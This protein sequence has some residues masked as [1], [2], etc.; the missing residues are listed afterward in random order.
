MVPMPML[1]AVR[2]RPGPSFRNLSSIAAAGLALAACA[3]SSAGPEVV[4]GPSRIVWVTDAY[5]GGQRVLDST[6]VDSLSGRWTVTRCGPVAAT[7][8]ICGA[9]DSRMT[10]GTMDTAYRLLLFERVLRSD[11]AALRADYPQVGVVPP[12]LRVQAL[13]VTLNQRR[14]TVRWGTASAIPPAA[15]SCTCFLQQAMGSLILCAN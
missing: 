4:A 7:G 11:F 1:R 14:Q 3:S 6:V 12:E 13:N 9:V 8:P 2:Q 10:T 5:A 15:E